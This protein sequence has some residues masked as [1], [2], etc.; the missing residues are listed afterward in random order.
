MLYC[1]PFLAATGDDGDD[2][3]R[4]VTLTRG[5]SFN[6]TGTVSLRRDHSYAAAAADLAGVDITAPSS[7]TSP[8]RRSR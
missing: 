5:Q 3:D 6:V 4:L 7:G 1:E 8:S 2:L